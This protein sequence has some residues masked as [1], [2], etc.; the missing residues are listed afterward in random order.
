[1]HL[2]CDLTAPSH[3]LHKTDLVFSQFSFDCALAVLDLNGFASA[4][5]ERGAAAL[6]VAVATALV[7]GAVFGGDPGPGAAGVEDEGHL[8][9]V[10]ADVYGT[11]VLQVGEV[12]YA[13]GEAVGP[14]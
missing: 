8:L 13:D 5:A 9:A 14:A 10:R 1:M 6:L 4:L 12:A 3:V 11:D 7:A 2:L